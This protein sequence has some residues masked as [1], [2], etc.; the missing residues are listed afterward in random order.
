MASVVNQPAK[1]DAIVV[2]AGHNGLVAACYL[3]GAGLNVCVLERYH[4]VGGATISEETIPGFKLSTGSYVLSL[5]PRKIFDELGAWEG[6]E[7]LERNPRFFAPF[8]DGSSLTYWLDDEQ[9]MKQ[10]RRINPNDA[11]AWWHYDDFVERA[12]RVMDKFILR[13]PPSWAEVAAEFRTPDDARAWTT[14]SD[15]DLMHALETEE[16]LG[17]PVTVAHGEARV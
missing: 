13:R 10:L 6:I 14:S 16:L 1:Y 12:C 4:E 2:G 15:P 17:R 5:A 3:A 9:W 7:L 8:P 11:E